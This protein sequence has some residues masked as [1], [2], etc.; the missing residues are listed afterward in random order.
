MTDAIPVFD[1]GI[2]GHGYEHRFGFVA[3]TPHLSRGQ[4]PALPQQPR[5][6]GRERTTG[7]RRLAEFDAGDGGEVTGRDHL[8]KPELPACPGPSVAVAP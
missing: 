5:H 6:L 2:V 4:T 7:P 8:G 3:H 1:G